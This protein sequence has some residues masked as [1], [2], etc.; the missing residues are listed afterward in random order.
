VIWRKNLYT[1]NVIDIIMEN[2][3]EQGLDLS[4]WRSAITL[5]AEP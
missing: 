5:A 1:R 2:R 4:P 3:E